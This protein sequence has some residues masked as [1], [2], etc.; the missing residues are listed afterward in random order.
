MQKQDNGSEYRCLEA[1]TETH[2]FRVQ[3]RVILVRFYTRPPNE[4]ANKGTL[5]NTPLVYVQSFTSDALSQSGVRVVTTPGECE[6]PVDIQGLF[7]SPLQFIFFQ[8]IHS[9]MPRAPTT[10]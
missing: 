5:V 9:G 1:T 3:P 10:K 6:H 7:F 8:G 2:Q 4:C